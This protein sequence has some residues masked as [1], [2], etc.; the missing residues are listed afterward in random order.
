MPRLVRYIVSFPQE[1]PPVRSKVLLGSD[2]VASA[3]RGHLG[4]GQRQVESQGTLWTVTISVK[5]ERIPHGRECIV[6][7]LEDESR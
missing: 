6:S 7:V 3:C 2:G 5:D 4:A 1:R